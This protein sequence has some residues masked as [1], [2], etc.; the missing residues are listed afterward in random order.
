MTT[1]DRTEKI[2]FQSKWYPHWFYTFAL[3]DIQKMDDKECCIT[4]CGHEYLA[5]ESTY[6]NVKRQWKEWRETHE[7][8]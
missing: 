1:F 4:I 3:K 5:T 8:Q 2:S 6:E 7:R